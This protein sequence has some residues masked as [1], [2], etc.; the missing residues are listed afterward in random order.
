MVLF[1][2]LLAGPVRAQNVE[3]L[4]GHQRATQD[5]MFFTFFELPARGEG[6]PSRSDLLVFFRAR[7]GVGYQAADSAPQFGLTSALSW[8]PAVLHGFAPVL[9]GQVFNKGPVA[10]AG[11]Q[12]ARV[13][14]QLTVFSWVVSELKRTPSVDVFALGRWLHP[15]GE[16]LALVFHVEALAS[17]PTSAEQPFAFTERVRVGLQ[18]HRVQLGPGLDV[19]HVGRGDFSHTLNVGGFVRVEL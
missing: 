12:Y 5:V 9:V 6:Q 1:A 10:K 8:N 14:R 11:I 4:V 15:L 3:L 2:P 16:L 18:V 13:S 19:G 7:A 17:F